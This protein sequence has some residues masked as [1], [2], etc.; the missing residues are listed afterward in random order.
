M[1]LT[2]SKATAALHRNH[3]LVS[4]FKPENIRVTQSGAI[5]FLDCD[6]FGIDARG[7]RVAPTHFSAGYISPE[8]L[9]KH[10]GPCSASFPQDLFAL[11]VLIFKLLNY[12]IHPFQGTNIS[13]G[14]FPSDDDKVREGLYPYGLTESFRIK[15]TPT[16]I[17]QDIDPSIRLLFDRCFQSEFHRPT[18]AEWSSAFDLLFNS[19][20]F[21]KCHSYPSDINHI[22]FAQLQCPVCRLNKFKCLP[23]KQTD[24][25]KGRTIP[26]PAAPVQQWSLNPN[27]ISYPLLGVIALIFF[28]FLFVFWTGGT[29]NHPKTLTEKKDCRLPTDFQMFMAGELCHLYHERGCKYDAIFQELIRRRVHIDPQYLCGQPIKSSNLPKSSIRLEELE[30]RQPQRLQ[31]TTLSIEELR[32]CVREA[33]W[34]DSS[35]NYDFSASYTLYNQR[36]NAYNEKCAERNFSGTENE[37]ASREI[38]ALTAEIQRELSRLGYNV[39]TIDGIYGVI[40]SDA[41]VQYCRDRGRIDSAMSGDLLRELKGA[42]L[43]RNRS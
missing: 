11:G 43:E 9:R 12:G 32:W 13:E 7:F 20:S 40:T 1:A 41:I 39:G 42:R 8:L 5:T 29:S 14:D 24:G 4:D 28:G 22:R 15:P 37:R 33:R 16:S 23:P 10:L 26:Q 34:I 3:F 6:S 36:I 25:S 19:Y 31:N 17:H 18:A 30:I 27:V 21:A 2:L 35:R 38:K